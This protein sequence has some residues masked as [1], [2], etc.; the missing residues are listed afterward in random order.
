MSYVGV[1]WESQRSFDARL[2]AQA[3]VVL[4]H[5]RLNVAHA[6]HKGSENFHPGRALTLDTVRK[7]FALTLATRT[8]YNKEARTSIGGSRE[9]VGAQSTDT[10][11]RPRRSALTSAPRTHGRDITCRM[12]LLSLALMRMEKCGGV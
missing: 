3:R 7:P 5:A 2:S 4:A 1:M 8:V 11:P 9:Q 12:S 10:L 6:A